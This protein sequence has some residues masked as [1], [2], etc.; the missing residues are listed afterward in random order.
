MDVKR[1]ETDRRLSASSPDGSL[2]VSTRLASDE[3]DLGFKDG[4]PPSPL[5]PLFFGD[6]AQ[7]KCLV[8]Q[9]TWKSQV[10]E[11]VSWTH[12][13]NEF[14]GWRFGAKL[15]AVCASFAFVVNLICTIWAVTTTAPYEDG[16]AGI[17]TIFA[18]DCAKAKRIDFWVHLAI[19]ILS[20]QSS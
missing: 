17:G 15:S 6:E 16:N 20:K 9:A 2:V 19:N 14:S 8:A 10:D 5:S 18:G 7:Q 4:Y 11:P 3:K 13:V 1:S 12:R